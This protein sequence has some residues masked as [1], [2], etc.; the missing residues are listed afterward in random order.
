MSLSF[1]RILGLLTKEISISLIRLWPRPGRLPD[2]SNLSA[3]DIEALHEITET[4]AWSLAKN[5]SAKSAAWQSP[6]CDRGAIPFQD[7]RAGNSQTLR[8]RREAMA[9]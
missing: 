2:P 8:L 1:S 7:R 4:R 9:R 5:G 3:E 6:R